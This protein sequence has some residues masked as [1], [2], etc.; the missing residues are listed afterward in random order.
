MGQTA[1]D[2]L[3]QIVVP[4]LMQLVG[5]VKV[6]RVSVEAVLAYLRRQQLLFDE[7]LLR[8]MFAEA[9]FRHEGSLATGPLTGALQGRYRQVYRAQ[10]RLCSFTNVCL[11]RQICKAEARAG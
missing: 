4:D 5:D 7:Q 6:Q 8:N 9:D 2:Q 11:I 1:A 3:R 10:L